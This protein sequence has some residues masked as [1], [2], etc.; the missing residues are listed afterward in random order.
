VWNKLEKIVMDREGD[1]YIQ[2][3]C[4]QWWEEWIGEG[5]EKHL[6]GQLK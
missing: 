4:W 1:M 5:L 6:D 3:K 2:V